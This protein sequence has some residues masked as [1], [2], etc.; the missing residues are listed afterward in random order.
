MAQAQ[1]QS[2]STMWLAMEAKPASKTVA[3]QAGA[4]TIAIT[5]KMLASDVHL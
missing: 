3:T 4:L 1:G 5:M 2:G